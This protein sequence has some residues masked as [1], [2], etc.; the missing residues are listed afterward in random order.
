MNAAGP[1][2]AILTLALAGP[3]AAAPAD[4]ELRSEILGVLT[5]ARVSLDLDEVPTR[6]ALERLGAT[7]GLNIIGRYDDDIVGHGLDP[8]IPITLRLDS[9][10]GRDA[11]EMIIDQAALYSSCSWQLR[12]GFVE[13]GTKRRLGYANER[14]IYPIG[15]FLLEPPYF[16]SGR[17]GQEIDYEHFNE[18]EYRSASLKI[19]DFRKRYGTQDLMEELIRAIAE[20]VEP[21]NWNFE[22]SKPPPTGLA[23]HTSG[24]YQSDENRVATVRNWRK[25]RL[26]IVAP[27]Y[28]HRQ[29]AGPGRVTVPSAKHFELRATTQPGMA[30]VG[31][32]EN[33]RG[34]SIFAGITEAPPKLEQSDDDPALIGGAMMGKD[35]HDEAIRTLLQTRIS[36]SF[37]ETPARDAIEHLPSVL[38]LPVIGR[39][40]DDE[41]GYGIDP[42][43]P[44]TLTLKDVPALAGLKAILDECSMFGDECTWQ[45]RRGYIEVGTKERLS[46]PAA[47][48]LRLYYIRDLL[49]HIGSYR[50]KRKLQLGIALDH[51]ETIVNTIEPDAWDWGQIEYYEDDG[52]Q[53]LIRKDTR[54]SRRPGGGADARRVT[55]PRPEY[56][57]AQ[58]PAIIRHW[59]DVLIV[60][61]P[62]YI[63]RELG[64]EKAPPAN[65]PVDHATDTAPSSR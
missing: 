65:R 56:V 46:V 16:D 53:G 23:K 9:V 43:L 29:V 36:F 25:N 22:L 61:A 31:I 62:D 17:L 1:L 40:S 21:G 55:R 60:L 51:V 3:V 48:T 37:D 6:E 49:L 45:I 15:D 41:L 63:H 14:R 47:R 34:P 50:E 42:D 19:G 20:V 24:P 57:E 44:I 8:T 13:V 12:T 30:V 5:H 27:D 35:F 11:L 38:G 32:D 54:G 39:F 64:G 28:F 26:L 33:R 4:D 10:S 2:I 58:K 52:D 18:H 59:R 7:L